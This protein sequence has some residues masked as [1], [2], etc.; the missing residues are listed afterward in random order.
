[1]NKLVKEGFL[2][3]AVRLLPGVES[4]SPL[5]IKTLLAAC[6]NKGDLASA[7]AVLK[8][9]NL[10]PTSQHYMLAIKICHRINR[11]PEVRHSSLSSRLWRSWCRVGEALA[12]IAL[13]PCPDRLV[14]LSVVAKRRCGCCGR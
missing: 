11:W 5:L 14:S 10:N 3:Q 12:F 7:L 9:P 2:K 8:L 6:L 13:G 1:M 4:P